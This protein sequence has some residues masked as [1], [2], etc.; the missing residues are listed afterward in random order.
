MPLMQPHEVAP[1]KYL[2]AWRTAKRVLA[3]GGAV[4][5]GRMGESMDAEAFTRWLRRDLDER[6]NYRGGFRWHTASRK[7]STDY[8]YRLVR[9]CRAVRDHV[10]TRLRVYRLETPDVRRRFAHIECGYR[11]D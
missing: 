4:Q 3:E 7:W 9:D 2:A 10:N 8:Q 5:N 11:G 1:A 6:I